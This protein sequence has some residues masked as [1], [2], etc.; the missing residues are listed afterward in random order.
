MNVRIEPLLVTL[1][2]N[3]RLFA[4]A[5]AGVDDAVGTTRPNSNTNHMAFIA[6]HLLDAR[7]YLAEYTG[8]ASD[9]PF[10]EILEGAKGIED[11]SEFPAL[12]DILLEWQGISKKL[13]EHLAVLEEGALNKDSP[14]SFPIED[15][16]VL[17]GITFLLEHESHH[18]GQLAYLRRYFALPALDWS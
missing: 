2:L 11:I 15:S 5:L 12:A 8:L 10:K 6:C 17:G 4:N 7:H 16:T 14:Q 1:N 13:S 9:K 3:G 18:I